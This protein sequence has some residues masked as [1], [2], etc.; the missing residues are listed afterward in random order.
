M[1]NIIFAH[2]IIFLSSIKYFRGS[3]PA[4][5]SRNLIFIVDKNTATSVSV[6]GR[7]VFL[8]QMESYLVYKVRFCLYVPLSVVAPPKLPGIQASSFTRLITSFG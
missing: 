3:I 1:P 8:S 7:K 2:C 4:V 5:K 6:K